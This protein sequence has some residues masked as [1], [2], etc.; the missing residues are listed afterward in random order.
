MAEGPSPSGT[1]P[2]NGRSR[3][4]VRF[5]TVSAVWDRWTAHKRLVLRTAVVAMSLAAVV[6]LG[7]EFYRLLR[8]PL[9]IGPIPIDRGAIDLELRYNDVHAWF[10]GVPIYEE[11]LNASYPPATNVL[12]WPLLG[13]L[14]VKPATWLWAF[15]GIVMLG[16]LVHLTVR[17]SLANTPLERLFVALIPLSM[18]ATG[19][20]IGNG[21]LITHL[22]PALLAGLCVL[23]SGRRD[24]PS[25][26]LAASLIVIS[27]VKPSVAAPFF[28][29][30]LFLPG[31]IRPAL[32][33]CAGYAA[34]TLFAASFQDAGIP[35]LI[36]QW[37]H[38]VE[39]MSIHWSGKWGS[40]DLHVLLRTAGWAKLAGPA[41]LLLLCSL[42]LWVCL[43][44]RVDPWILIGTTGIVARLWTYHGWYD[45]LLIL[46]P[47]I[48]LIR[49]VKLQA[50]A[51]VHAVTAGVLLGATLAVSIAPG[52][53]FLLPPPFSSYYVG[54]QTLIWISDLAFLLVV[55]RRDRRAGAFAS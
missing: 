29:I 25:D 46:L 53:L 16:W 51:D 9:R 47:M 31:R 36:E 32:M 22:L 49:T 30:V 28:W 2:M 35:L 26:L 44:R 17:E 40:W 37:L 6:W 24:L 39:K 8:Q 33:V 43:H 11:T 10:A 50:G 15:T 18:Y 41:S 13:W 21:Q 7:Y 14:G 55:A 45:D 5:D 38:G 12:L 1:H 54:L 3:E 4:P 20:S 19:A 48:A 52:G 42:G 34:L 27:L 23:A